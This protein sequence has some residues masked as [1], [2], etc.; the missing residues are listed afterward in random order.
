MYLDAA[1]PLLEEG[2]HLRQ[3]VVRVHVVHGAASLLQQ[4]DDAL[5]LNLLVHLELVEG[6]AQRAQEG[7]EVLVVG[8]VG[9]GKL[10]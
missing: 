8:E 1:Q 3:L 6:V 9:L 2:Q 7:P 10:W 4:A 5:V